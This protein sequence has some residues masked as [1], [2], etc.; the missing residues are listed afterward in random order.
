M[1]FRS[2]SSNFR[3][4]APTLCSITVPGI[5]LTASLEPPLPSK[6]AVS[7]ET[8]QHCSP[9]SEDLSVS[10]L[11]CKSSN[12]EYR[13]HTPHVADQQKYK[14]SYDPV[15]G[16]STYPKGISARYSLGKERS[17]SF[18]GL[19][20]LSRKAT[21]NPRPLGELRYTLH[22]HRTHSVK[23]VTQN[24]L[25]KCCPARSSLALD[26]FHDDTVGGALATISFLSPSPRVLV[27]LSKPRVR[28]AQG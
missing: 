11:L 14:Q 27:S 19:N 4:K 28:L 22:R 9:L 13:R 7:T 16:D 10:H 15:Q 8:A 12:L 18:N 25:A 26:Q 3:K 5:C 23:A 2:S 20:T 6:P 17:P 1:T 21:Y 24:H